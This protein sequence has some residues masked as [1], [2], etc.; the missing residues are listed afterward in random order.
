[1]GTTLHVEK[2]RIE[3]GGAFVSANPPNEISRH[4]FRLYGMTHTCIMSAQVTQTC[5]V[6]A[7]KI[8]AECILPNLLEVTKQQMGIEYSSSGLYFQFQGSC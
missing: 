4:T 5:I 2:G 6:T 7:I 3:L 8:S 1:M